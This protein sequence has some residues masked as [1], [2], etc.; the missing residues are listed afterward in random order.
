MGGSQA[1]RGAGGSI[2]VHVH[3]LSDAPLLA[4]DDQAV[5]EALVTA[6]GVDNVKRGLMDLQVP[7]DVLASYDE[8]TNMRPFSLPKNALHYWGPD[9]SETLGR[10]MYDHHEREKEGQLSRVTGWLNRFLGLQTID[11]LETKE[12][13]VKVPVLF[14]AAPSVSGI[15]VTV[16]QVEDKERSAGFE[17]TA[18]G[19]SLGAT[20]SYMIEESLAAECHGGASVLLAHVRVLVER[21]SIR[22]GKEPPRESLRCQA[23]GVQKSLTGRRAKPADAAEAVVVETFDADLSEGD[24]NSVLH[25]GRKRSATTKSEPKI[26]IEIGKLKVQMPFVLSSMR[27]IETSAELPGGRAYVADFLASPDGVRWR[28]KH[29]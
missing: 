20:R 19:T 27:S 17:V 8:A 18:Y 23:L 6:Y 2:A 7:A 3:E 9:P 28:A 13:V 22:A 11:V 25:V 1:P 26:G 15:T 10:M 4:G 14:V 16:G 12:V 29:A 21:I 5:D 24:P